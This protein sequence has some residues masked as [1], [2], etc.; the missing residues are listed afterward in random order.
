[1]AKETRAAMSAFDLTAN[2]D[3]GYFKSEEILASEAAG[4]TPLAPKPLTSGAKADGRFG[5]QD[6]VYDPGEDVYRCPAGVAGFRKQAMLFLQLFAAR[7]ELEVALWIERRSQCEKRFCRYAARLPRSSG[8]P[9]I[10][11]EPPASPRL[12]RVSGDTPSPRACTIADPTA[13]RFLFD[14]AAHMRTLPFQAG[15]GAAKNDAFVR[16]IKTRSS[17]AASHLRARG[18]RADHLA[19]S[20]R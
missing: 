9:S 14:R 6:F 16:R 10:S 11:A 19:T 3:R 8:Q 4:V 20:A 2:A 13:L 15:S 7:T 12:A 1:M 18:E 17:D 5:K